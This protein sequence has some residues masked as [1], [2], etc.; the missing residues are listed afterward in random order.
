[1]R[2]GEYVRFH[3]TLPSRLTELTTLILSRYWTCQFPFS[4]HHKA[5]TQAGLSESIVAAIA[6]GK[7]PA[8][9]EKDEG[10]PE[11]QDQLLKTTQISDA[12]FTAAKEPQERI[13]WSCWA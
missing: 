5:A 8:G 4:V 2:Y 9:M 11:S 10:I 1:M 3:S 13:W 6:G 12:N 7:R